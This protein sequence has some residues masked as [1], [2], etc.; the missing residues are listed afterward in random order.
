MR[1]LKSKIRLMLIV[2]VLCSLPVSAQVPSGV[3]AD[4]PAML[5]GLTISELID[6]FGV[7]RSVH[8]A[9]GVET[10]QDDVVFVYDHGDFYIYE[11][12]VWQIGVRSLRGIN[13]GDLSGLVGLVMGSNAVPQGSS[14]FYPLHI[15]PWPLMLRWDIDSAGRV[16][17]IF[18]YRSDL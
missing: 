6:R 13:V 12:R 8:A 9:R 2:F 18:I 3:W 4:E 1:L 17:S 10:W 5:V 14:I 11:Y 7:P 15:A 16:Q